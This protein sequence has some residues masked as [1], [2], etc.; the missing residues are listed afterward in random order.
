MALSSWSLCQC[1][2]WDA[3]K[4]HSASCS[5]SS[6]PELIPG[7]IKQ[8][9]RRCEAPNVFLG[10]VLLLFAHQ[11]V[12]SPTLPTNHSHRETR[13]EQWSTQCSGLRRTTTHVCGLYIVQMCSRRS[14][15]FLQVLTVIDKS[16][17]LLSFSCG[18]WPQLPLSAFA[19]L[20]IFVN[21]SSAFKFER[22]HKQNQFPLRC[23]LKKIIENFWS[24]QR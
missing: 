4:W 5:I 16:L 20:N 11:S 12:N 18:L 10:R 1:G 6:Q 13:G 22:F 17:G 8:T 14:C 21:K 15:V 19:P 7:V 23:W 9:R 3:V 24:D 2:F